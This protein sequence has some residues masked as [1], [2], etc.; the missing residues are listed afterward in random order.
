[1]RLESERWWSKGPDAEALEV[2]VLRVQLY[3]DFGAEGEQLRRWLKTYRASHTDEI[4]SFSLELCSELQDCSYYRDRLSQDDELRACKQAYDM[5]DRVLESSSCRKLDSIL[6]DYLTYS[7][8]A[9]ARNVQKDLLLRR[10]AESVAREGRRLLALELVWRD[11]RDLVVE[12]PRK[13]R[14]R[15][16]LRGLLSKGRTGTNRLLNLLRAAGSAPR[17]EASHKLRRR[18]LKLELHTLTWLHRLRSRDGA[19]QIPWRCGGGTNGYWPAVLRVS[20]GRKG[21]SQPTVLIP[22]EDSGTG[23][24]LRAALA[25]L[26][27]VLRRRNDAIVLTNSEPVLSA[28][29]QMRQRWN[30]RRMVLMRRTSPWLNLSRLQQ[31]LDRLLPGQSDLS[32]SRVVSQLPVDLTG[33]AI[34]MDTRDW[35][36]ILCSEVR[37]ETVIAVGEGNVLHTLEIAG[38]MGLPT[39]GVWPIL[40]S[41]YPANRRWPARMHLLYG[42]QGVDVLRRAGAAADTLQSVGTEHF[43]ACVR[44]SRRKQSDRNELLRTFPGAKG[45]PVI[46]LAT[47]ARVDQMLEFGPAMEDLAAQEDLFTIVKLHPDDAEAPFRA[48]WRRLGRPDNMVVVKRA[49]MQMLANACDLLISLQSNVMIEAAAMGVPSLAVNFSGVPCHLDLVAE[50]IC[51]GC[52]EREDLVTTVRDMLPGGRL[53]DQALEKLRAIHRFNGPNDGR[54]VIRIVDI[55]L[56]LAETCKP[57]GD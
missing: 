9:W 51:L 11:W 15:S 37:L 20:E 33:M 25:I 13:R 49:D 42:R 5:V 6:G 31:E 41:D 8:H 50:G 34:V 43:D 4:V 2:R 10:L 35:L 46:V 27:E 39:C 28:L 22:V 45:K 47:E 24:N 54:S 16:T 14:L 1:M 26:E 3:D 32:G 19:F 23:A 53:R 12:L 38:R 18:F 40:I 36:G 17:T 52:R 56:N 30:L 29:E 21:S 44:R 48:L 7:Y 57:C 55:A